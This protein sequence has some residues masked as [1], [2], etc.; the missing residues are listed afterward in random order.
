[1]V[2]LMFQVMAD[3]WAKSNSLE[4]FLLR[5][6]FTSF[7]LTCSLVLNFLVFW[8]ALAIVLT[9]LSNISRNLT[10]NEIINMDRYTH[11]Y[12]PRSVN[13]VVKAAF[14]NPFS[15]VVVRLLF[16]ACYQRAFAKWGC[17]PMSDCDSRLDSAPRKQTS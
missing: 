9:Q 8:M 17:V 2:F 3:V 14:S 13:G 11:F 7:G 4:A 16:A 5:G 12:E 1:M 6:L 10:L 15:Q